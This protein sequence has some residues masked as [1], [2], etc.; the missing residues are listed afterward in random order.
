LS[1]NFYITQAS[2][3]DT[4]YVGTWVVLSWGCLSNDWQVSWCQCMVCCFGQFSPQCLQTSEGWSL[5]SWIVTPY[6]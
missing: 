3:F 2:L 6:V 5:A 4:R 1:R